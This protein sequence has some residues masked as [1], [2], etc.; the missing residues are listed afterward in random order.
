[1]ARWILKY[2]SYSR[3]VLNLEMRQIGHSQADGLSTNLGD[4]K[5]QQQKT[6]TVALLECFKEK[7]AAWPLPNYHT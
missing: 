4:R 2:F 5:K 3:E 7:K 1:M 6:A